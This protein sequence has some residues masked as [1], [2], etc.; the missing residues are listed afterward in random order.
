MNPRFLAVAGGVVVAAL[1]IVL[2]TLFTVEQIEQ[3]LVLQFGKPIRPIEKPGLYAKWPWQNVVKYDR[4]VLDFEPPAEEVIAADQKRLVVDA[5]ARFRIANPLL[6]YQAVGTEPVAR[7]RLGSIISGALRRVIGNVDLQ[8]VVADKR[9]P[10]MRQVRDEVSQ[11]AKNFGID[12]IDLRIRRSDLPEENSQAIY[13]RMKSERQREAAQ[14]RAQG[15]QQAQAIRAD[16]DRQRIEILADA[17]KQSQILRGQGDAD[18]I[19]IYADAFGRDKDF[20][21]FYRSLQAYREGLSGQ[22]TTLVLSP[23]SPFFRFLEGGPGAVVEGAQ[24]GQ[25][26]PGPAAQR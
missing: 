19:K 24:G 25:A 6:F 7:A 1:V 17:Q 2:T 23:D 8:S 10:T 13:D 14:F 26:A 12:V 22:G 4:R 20:F 21:S 18:S 3:A 15:A 5:Y 11:Q 9:A 16:A